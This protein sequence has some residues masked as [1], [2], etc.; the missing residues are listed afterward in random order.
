MAL[1]ARLETSGGATKYLERLLGDPHGRG[2]SSSR[3]SSTSSSS[4]VAAVVAVVVAFVVVAV[5]ADAVDASRPPP[6]EY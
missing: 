2:S 3:S 6:D 4:P 5:D 1:G